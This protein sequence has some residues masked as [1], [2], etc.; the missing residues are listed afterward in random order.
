MMFIYRFY[1]N[2]LYRC[3]RSLFARRWN[4]EP[5]KTFQHTTFIVIGA[6]TVKIP[7]NIFTIVSLM[8][9][10][11]RSATRETILPYTTNEYAY[12]TALPHSLI[13]TCAVPY[14]VSIIPVLADLNCSRF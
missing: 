9:I 6:L 14:Q 8:V 1:N 13:S 12:Q 4:Q 3:A 10:D 11:I 2:G 7:R 5:S